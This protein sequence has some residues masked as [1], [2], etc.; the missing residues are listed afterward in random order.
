MNQTNFR[1]YKPCKPLQPYVRYYW[2]FES[3]PP[4]NVL[5][6]PIG[7]P[8]L[9]FHKKK[10]LYVP[11]LGTWQ[12]SL[13]VS[14]QVNYPSHLCSEGNVEML[15]AV[16]KPYGMKAFFNQPMSLL[17]N[18]EI[19]VYDFGNKELLE[20]GIRILECGDT[21]RC[22]CMLEQ[23]LLSQMAGM[24]TAQ[25]ALDMRRMIAAMQCLLGQD[26]VRTPVSPCGGDQSQGVCANRPF[27]EVAESYATSYGRWEP[28]PAG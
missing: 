16:F 28:G 15:V 22:V 9:I 4:L 14:G 10:T 23:W 7:C 20:L 13:A 25:A 26:A 11:E 24:Q 1:F 17:Y 12:A 19:S 3:D 8:Q 21:G 5:T 18:Q 6:F 2:A 27:S